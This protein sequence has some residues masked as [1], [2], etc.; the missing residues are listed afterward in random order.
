MPIVIDGD[1]LIPGWV[2]DHES[3]RRWAKSAEFPS[4]G[5]FSF[6]KGALWV[7]R[8][9]EQLFT[10]NRVKGQYSTIL[11]LLTDAAKNGY[12]FFDRTLLSHPEAGLSTEP[13]GLF[14]TYDALNSGRIRLIEGVTQ[15]YVE[16]E[17]TPDMILEVVS[18]SSVKKDMEVL[19]ELY[20]KAGVREYWL[21]DARGAESIFQIWQ[22]D[23]GV[24][25][26]TA[27]DDDWLCSSVFGKAFRLHQDKD[28]LGHPRFQLL[29]R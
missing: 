13:D 20:A 27:N 23:E 29:V 18:E 1:V 22:L 17:G 5:W 14:F 6:L 2:V 15:G 4:S 11:N 9:M 28:H 21:V 3:Y 19:K 10:H 26:P 12:F 8:T 24:Y 25:R 16:L 7:D